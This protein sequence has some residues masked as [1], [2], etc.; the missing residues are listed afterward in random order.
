MEVLLHRTFNELNIN[1]AEQNIFITEALI[2]SLSNKE[3]LTEIMFETFDIK[4]LC[5]APQP[6]LPLYAEDNTTGV[7]V[8]SG[9]GLTQIV[10]I[11]MGS[12]MKEGIRS[13]E[14]AGQDVTNE[15]CK[16]LANTTNVDM[17]NSQIIKETLCTVMSSEVVNDFEVKSFKINEEKS[18]SIGKEGVLSPEILF[19]HTINEIKGIQGWINK[20]ILH[21]PIDTRK[22]LLG[23]IV[24]SGGNSLLP[25]FAKRL[26][27]E[28]T[29]LAPSTVKV[30]VQAS[31]ERIYS[32]WKGASVLASLSTYPDICFTKQEYGN[33]GPSIVHRNVFF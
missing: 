25:G 28:V 30:R 24:I 16:R 12:V 6:L 33:T 27:K 1:P 13:V 3:K 29:D 2:N 32:V 14:L 5:I 20:S 17:Q 10:P 18:I 9:H 23:S 26:H 19:N 31:L 8:E 21:C 22:Q 7:V 15:L 11:F 4:T